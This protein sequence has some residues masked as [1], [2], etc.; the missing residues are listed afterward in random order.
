MCMCVGYS[1]S[2]ALA[3]KDVQAVG[4]KEVALAARKPF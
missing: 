1:Q 4:P 3:G 2:S